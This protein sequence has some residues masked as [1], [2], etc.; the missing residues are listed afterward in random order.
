MSKIYVASSWRNDRQP[1]V[2]E[3]LRDAGH[4][5]YDF[6][7]P[8]PGDNGFHWSEIDPDWQ[9]WSP[10]RFRDCLEHPI[11]QDGFAKDMTA[12]ASCEVCVLV[13]PCGISA[14]LELG[15][16]VGAGKRT[17]VLLADGEPEL[18]YR[19]V[20]QM[21]LSI[22]EAVEVLSSDDPERKLWPARRCN[23]CDVCKSTFEHISTPHCSGCT[24]P[25]PSRFE[26]DAS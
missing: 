15:W 23:A 22:E 13:Q 16:A 26:H 9:S 4:D 10:E 21:V 6:R 3:A 24:I 5:V 18:M 7:N 12:L 8:E 17:A 11:A 2:V 25:S 1:A 14:H 19:M 20:D